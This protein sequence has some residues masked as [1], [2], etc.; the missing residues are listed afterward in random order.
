MVPMAARIHVTF[1]VLNE[2]DVLADSIER[3]LAFCASNGVAIDEFCIAD[4]GS[5]DRTGEIGRA[6]AA[7]YANV[8]YLHLEQRGFGLAL[9]SAW[10]A[11]GADFIGYMD[12]DL[13]TELRHLRE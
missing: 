2:E 12:I 9:K 3:T 1:P 11:S 6:L 13:A 10:N 5:T 8:S 7:R 4:N